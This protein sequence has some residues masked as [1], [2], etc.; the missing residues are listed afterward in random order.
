MG[1]GFRAWAT[2][3]LEWERLEHPRGRQ[4]NDWDGR[5]APPS[6]KSSRAKVQKGRTMTSTT[7]K[8]TAMPGT[9]FMSLSA[10]PLIGRTPFSSFLP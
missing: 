5:Y 6:G 3:N 7:I 4:A 9:S 10:L 8:A 1:N 2:E